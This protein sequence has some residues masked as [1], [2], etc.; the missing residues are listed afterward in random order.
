VVFSPAPGKADAVLLG[1]RPTGLAGEGVVAEV[2]FEVLRPGE[3]RIDIAGIV[4]RDLA[5]R[6]VTVNRGVAGAHLLPQATALA[7]AGANPFRGSTA[8]ELALAHPGRVEAELFSVDGRRVRRLM[9]GVQEPGVLRL[10][11]NGRDDG[12]RGMPAGVYFLRVEADR[13]HFMRRLVLL[14]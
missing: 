7:M 9:E 2:E 6:P 13:Q 5:N 4:A 1:A 12:G 8:L 14:Q 3:P 10:E 11:W